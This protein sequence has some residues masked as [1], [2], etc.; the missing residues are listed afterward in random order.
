M[1]DTG[2][3]LYQLSL[4]LEQRLGVPPL[5]CTN[6]KA[7]LHKRW[8]VEPFT[9]PDLV[10]NRL[11]THHG[12]VGTVMGEGRV[13][14]DLDI[15]KEEG[16]RT[17]RMLTDLGWLPATAAQHTQSGGLHLL[18]S[19]DPAVWDIGCGDFEKITGPDGTPFPG[20][21]EWKG[22][23]GYLV[24]YGWD[25]AAIVGI[26][27]ALATALSVGRRGPYLGPQ[28][29]HPMTLE[30]CA[31]LEQ[32]FGA[33]RRVPATSDDGRPY[34]KLTRPGKNASQGTSV[35][36]GQLGPGT[37]FFHTPNWPPFEELQVVDLWELRRMAGIVIPRIT[38]PPASG[39]ELPPGFRLWKPGDVDP[40]PSL[41][42]A[43]YHGPVG[44]YLELLD[45]NTEAHPA[46]IGALLLSHL[47]VLIGHRFEAHIGTHRH[48]PV[49]W[50]A[51]V[52]PSSVGAKGTAED[53]AE[54]L[55]DAVDP[56]FYRQ[57]SLAGVGS[58][59]NLVRSIRDVDP[60]SN[61]PPVEKDRLIADAEL[62][63]MF[64]V[65]GRE[66]S[67]LSEYLRKAY[68]S[69]LLRHSSNTAGTVLASARSYMVNIAGAITPVDLARVTSEADTANGWLNRFG[70]VWAEAVATLPRGGRRQDDAIGVLAAEIVDGVGTSR[71]P[72]AVN[73]VQAVEPD[74]SFWERWDP[75]YDS[76]RF[77]AGDTVESRLAGRYINHACRVAL[78][79]A[80]LDGSKRL[81]G[82]HL[83]A[84]LGW[85]DY[86]R[87]TVAKVF[88][89]PAGDP[90]KLL[91]A[92]RDAGEEGLT[93]TEQS[94]L[95]HRHRD[96]D[97]LAGI[98]GELERKGLA[99]TV[100][101][102]TTQRPTSRTY[103]TTR[104]GTPAN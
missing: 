63:A 91:V 32:H 54:R 34:V 13:G 12:N 20:G 93:F 44:R 71:Q 66:G 37:S 19:Y 49:V 7:A 17:Y 101:D 64:K 99:V 53:D 76:L 30:A 52:G 5:I 23:G 60:A 25:E 41:A 78:V 2:P 69:K 21:A 65:A 77:P 96:T 11:R 42:P 48:P 72:L 36:V 16:A 61:E 87:G 84:A 40:A 56:G 22:T 3:D 10:R 4:A 47:G 45:G 26:Q 79:Y 102:R 38:V 58:G 15:Y 80:V 74:D 29:L 83:A 103:A 95:F 43:V 9:H 82:A 18:Y 46:A 97:Q 94:V 100:E 24:V 27:P 28:V 1:G 90:G 6:H 92:L 33:H 85:V 8:Q 89:H 59:E 31:L 67:V 62:A 104:H 68:D 51:I 50:V 75:V 86:F 81:T 14:I 98:R 70:F 35:S 39:P 88:A 57:H 55:V 73:G